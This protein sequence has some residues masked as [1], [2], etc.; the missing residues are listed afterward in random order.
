MAKIEA[1]V[2]ANIGPFERAL[3]KATE[4]AREFG[5]KVGEVGTDFTREVGGSKVANVLGLAGGVTAAAA[6]G[7]G[8][9]ETAKTGLEAFGHMETRV[10]SLKANLKDP[11]VAES[12][13]KW[14]ESLPAATGSM[15]ELTKGFNQLVESGLGLQQAGSTL[16]DLSAISI[17]TGESIT[18]LAEAFRKAKAGG[19]DAGEG[20]SRLLKGIPGLAAAMQPMIDQS[21]NDYLRSIGHAPG[22]MTG[23]TQEQSAEYQKRKTETP[24][25]YV[26]S[27]QFNTAGLEQLLHQMADPSLIME[28]SGTLEGHEAQLGRAFEELEVSIGAKLAPTIELF[29]DKLAAALPG[30]SDG[31]TKVAGEFANDVL[32]ALE[33]FAHY[34][35]GLVGAVTSEMGKEGRDLMG[36]FTDLVKE[37]RM[38]PATHELIQ[39]AYPN[40]GKDWSGG[41]SEEFKKDWWSLG[42]YKNLGGAFPDFGAMQ[43]SNYRAKD[44][45]INPDKFD[46]KDVVA[47]IKENTQ[48]T[49]MMMLDIN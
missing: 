37:G 25:D 36:H 18:D 33:G 21:A 24:E 1:E 44:A 22:Y 32:P 31:I 11:A 16:L 19:L 5:R 20:A 2:T 6:L 10:L 7:A 27:K 41:E 42:T 35:K 49:K 14:L 28:K 29:A 13:N 12:V 48:V 8:I 39:G 23:I 38:D 26:K 47:A 43:M 34:L 30:L 3:T 17:K 4:Q 15:D 40:A 9:V 46:N 45:G